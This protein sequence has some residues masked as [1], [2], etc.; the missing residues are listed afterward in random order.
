[1]GF[2]MGLMGRGFGRMG[3]APSKG[4]PP[5][6]FAILRDAEGNILRDAQGNILIV[7]VA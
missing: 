4:G 6:G 3:A 2:G 5:A 7:R 1:M